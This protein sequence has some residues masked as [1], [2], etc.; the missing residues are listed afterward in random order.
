MGTF[1]CPHFRAD[2]LILNAWNAH[3][4]TELRL[5]LLLYSWLHE[6]NWR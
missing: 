5:T 4:Q 2:S 6:Y 1:M 3:I